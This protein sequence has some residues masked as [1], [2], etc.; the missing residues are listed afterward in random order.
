MT[1]QLYSL[2]CARRVDGLLVFRKM[3]LFAPN[4]LCMVSAAP[5]TQGPILWA[6]GGLMIV[7]YYARGIDY[8]A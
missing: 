1:L 3:G 2:I 8:D 6:V 7:V 5:L 4:V